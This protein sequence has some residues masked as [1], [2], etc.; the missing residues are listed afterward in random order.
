MRQFGFQHVNVVNMLPTKLVH[1]FKS[2]DIDAFLF[3]L[4]NLL[5]C[6]LT[7]Y[8]HFY[9]Y[10]VQLTQTASATENVHRRLHGLLVSQDICISMRIKF[11]LIKQ[12]LQKTIHIEESSLNNKKYIADIAGKI[13]FSYRVLIILNYT[14]KQIV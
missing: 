1:T 4:M 6:I 12:L 5:K 9:A 7:T 2:S 14:P 11:N 10:K 3:I 13:I 8:L